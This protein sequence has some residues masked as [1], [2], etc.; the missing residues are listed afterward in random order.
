MSLFSEQVVVPMDKSEREAWLEQ[1][2]KERQA[3]KQKEAQVAADQLRQDKE[4]MWRPYE[5]ACMVTNELNIA[6]KG[7]L[8]VFHWNRV[9][10]FH[11]L[12][13]L[14]ITGHALTELPPNLA[15]AL[16]LLQSLCLISNRLESLP[17]NV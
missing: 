11:E 10:P 5:H 4:H 1:K 8:D 14:R 15:T 12:V 3:Q 9:F 13:A 17:E 2:I 16:P 7:E 6:W